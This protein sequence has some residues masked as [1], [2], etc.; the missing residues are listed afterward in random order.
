MI[1]GTNKNV[2]LSISG[3]EIEYKTLS[4]AAEAQNDANIAIISVPGEFALEEAKSAIEHDMNVF[5][6]SD[7]P[8]EEEL[9]LKTMAKEKGLFVMGRVRV[10]R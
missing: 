10:Q 3:K 2:S 7:M 4:I 8:L 1:K 9:E 6:F 5:I